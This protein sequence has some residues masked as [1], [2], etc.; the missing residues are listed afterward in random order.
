MVVACDT[1]MAW[2]LRNIEMLV[3]LE[4]LL[5]Y[6]SHRIESGCKFWCLNDG[7]LSGRATRGA[8]GK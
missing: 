7:S 6:G 4:L 8:V 1:N 5:N 3:I 2:I